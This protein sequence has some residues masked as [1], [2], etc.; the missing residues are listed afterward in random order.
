M[1]NWYK[2]RQIKRVP[3]EP[4]TQLSEVSPPAIQFLDQSFFR[5]ALPQNPSL[6]AQLIELMP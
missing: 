1:A 5:A 2:A 6:G 3:L 4:Q